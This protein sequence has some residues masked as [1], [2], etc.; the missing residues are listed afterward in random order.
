MYII[1]CTHDS[2][3]SSS[4]RTMIIVGPFGCCVEL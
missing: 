2:S 1:P 3:S 4:S